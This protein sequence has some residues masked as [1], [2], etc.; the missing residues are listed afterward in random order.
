VST[1]DSYD[2]NTAVSHRKELLGAVDFSIWPER[3]RRFMSAQP[4][5]SG[6]VVIG[7]LHLPSAGGSSGTLMFSATLDQAGGRVKRDY[8]LRHATPIGLFHSYNLPGQYAI[9]K[10][11]QGRGVPIP[12]VVGLDADGSLLGVIGYVMERVEGAVPPPSYYRVGLLVESSPEQR[13]AMILDAIATLAK[14]HALDWRTLGV[15]FLLQRGKGGTAIER[16]VDWYWSAL[17]W[18]CPGEIERHEPLRQWF[19]RNQPVESRICLNHGDAQVGNNLF[20]DNRVA[21]M[22]DWEL[23]ALGNPAND[24]AW[25]GFTH[26]F[27]GLGC[28]PLAGFLQEADWKAE[29]ERISG[30][31]LEHW[32]FYLA[33]SIF[34]VHVSIELVFRDATQELATA[35][36][37]A[38]GYTWQRVADQQAKYRA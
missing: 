19:L 26:S 6:E 35:K 18:G 38:L 20:R 36:R 21:A 4:G 1:G 16:D 31:E 22:L 14:L 33:L 8:V 12:G 27:L 13:K 23:A 29:Y 37:E 10:G 32:D 17:S 34:K 30:R 11:L 7:D 25:Q 2:P 15:E 28:E 5:V 24:V 3:L 9:L